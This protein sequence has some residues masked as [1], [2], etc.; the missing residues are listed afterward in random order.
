LIYINRLARL[1]VLLITPLLLIVAIALIRSKF[2]NTPV[3]VHPEFHPYLES[4]KKDADT[5]KVR[6]DFYKM[7]TV[8]SSMKGESPVAAYCLPATN[9]VVVSINT[10]NSIDFKTRKALL[11]HEWGHCLLKRDHTDD[12]DYSTMCPKSLMFPYIDPLQ[13]CYRLYE[14]SYNKELFTNPY[15]YKTFARREK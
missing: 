5:Y 11:Y 13:R 7:V 3:Y 14:S 15:N 2:T 9:T 10:W 8:F 12:V 1:L 4:F 6:V